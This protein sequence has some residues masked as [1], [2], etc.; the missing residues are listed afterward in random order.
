MI[1]GLHFGM[2]QSILTT[3]HG[4][5]VTPMSQVELIFEAQHLPN[6]DTGSKSDPQVYVMTKD[7]RTGEWTEVG[8]TEMIKDT[9]SPKW[10]KSVPM[11]MCSFYDFCNVLS[12][13]F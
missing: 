1:F 10:A 5:S 8:K 12:L 2:A 11:G 7:V 4:G 9:L 6:L 13:L 3:T